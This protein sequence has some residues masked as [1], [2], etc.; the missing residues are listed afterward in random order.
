MRTEHRGHQTGVVGSDMV[1]FAFTFFTFN[2]SPSR[3]SESL[4]PAPNT[5]FSWFFVAHLTPMATG[6]IHQKTT[7]SDFSAAQLFGHA[8][9]EL[10][11]D[12]ASGTGNHALSEAGYRPACTDISGVLE[13]RVRS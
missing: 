4:E 1:E 13:K 2:T 10:L 9:E 11:N 5:V 3:T 8:F 12:H 7:F 6:K